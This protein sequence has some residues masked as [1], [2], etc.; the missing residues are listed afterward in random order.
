LGYIRRIIRLYIIF[1]HIYSKRTIIICTEFLAVIIPG[2]D[3]IILVH[4][5]EFKKHLFVYF[6]NK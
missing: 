3:K 4:Q 6:K 2:N 5:S 1:C